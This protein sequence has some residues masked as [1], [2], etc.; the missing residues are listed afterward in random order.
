MPKEAIS[1]S[2]APAPGAPY[3]QAIRAGD[4]LFVAGQ[5]PID[6]TTRKIVGDTIEEQT[7]QVL[8]NIK[9]I[10]AAAG[11]SMGDVVKSTVH[12]SDLAHFARFN[13]EYVKHF[14]DPLPVRTTVGSQLL[15]FMVEIDVIAYVGE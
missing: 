2:N 11:A 15:G 7:A 14:P 8:A 12:L 9:S 6:P 5:V 1:T 13:E 4:F 10:L 3:S